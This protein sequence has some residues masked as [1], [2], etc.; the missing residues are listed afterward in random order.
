MSMID[1]DPRA[2][3]LYDIVGVGLVV[4]GLVILFVKVM[5]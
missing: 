3:L 2:F 1:K 4:V 5:P